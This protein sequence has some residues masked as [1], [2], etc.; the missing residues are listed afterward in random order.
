MID[1]SD[2]CGL[3]RVRLSNGD[4][5]DQVGSIVIYWIIQFEAINI[6]WLFLS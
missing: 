4:E 1:R 6:E 3:W 5:I 2:C